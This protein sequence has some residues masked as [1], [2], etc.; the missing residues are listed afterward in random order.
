MLAQIAAQQ[1]VFPR[2]RVILLEYVYER[3][4]VVAGGHD[5][6]VNPLVSSLGRFGRKVLSNA[7]PQSPR[8]IPCRVDV[9]NVRLPVA[10]VERSG[11][12]AQYV[13]TE[14]VRQVS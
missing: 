4:L 5:Q 3:Q 7:L 8:I 12:V 1:L 9:G 13:D 14:P 10:P 2:Q 6:L 11:S